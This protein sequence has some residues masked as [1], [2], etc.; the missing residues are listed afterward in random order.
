MV[1]AIQLS[2]QELLRCAVAGDPSWQGIGFVSE[3][4]DGLAT[5]SFNALSF[6]DEPPMHPIVARIFASLPS[7]IRMRKIHLGFSVFQ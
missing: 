4:Q 1:G 6:R 7:G 5:V 3:E 2:R